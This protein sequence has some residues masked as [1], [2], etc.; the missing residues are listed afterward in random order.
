MLA[1][2]KA[3]AGADRL[4][5]ARTGAVGMMAEMELPQFTEQAIGMPSSSL[6]HPL[7]PPGIGMS[8][9][10]AAD[11]FAAMSVPRTPCAAP[12]TIRVRASRRP[13]RRRTFC[14]IGSM[15]AIYYGKS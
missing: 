11:I 8:L 2:A 13:S 6:L 1:S 12:E 15:I 4:T 14:V 5:I 10:D 7:H 3:C 9:V